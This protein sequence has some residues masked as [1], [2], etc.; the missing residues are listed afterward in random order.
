MVFLLFCGNAACLS[1]VELPQLP[2]LFLLMYILQVR[3][4][5]AKGATAA[6]VRYRVSNDAIC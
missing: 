3:K 4:N 2:L 5:R 1:F 6:V